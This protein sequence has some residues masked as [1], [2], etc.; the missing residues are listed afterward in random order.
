MMF[1]IGIQQPL[2]RNSGPFWWG[3]VQSAATYF[4]L[5][6]S[7]THSLVG[8]LV[9]SA[10]FLKGAEGLRYDLLSGIVASCTVGGRWQAA[11]C[12]GHTLNALSFPRDAGFLSPLMGGVLGA[13]VFFLIS[14]NVLSTASPYR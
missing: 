11:P 12:P 5:P 8:G 1:A 13:L 10:Y 9:G 6:V 14:R 7:T 4:S 2:T 3:W